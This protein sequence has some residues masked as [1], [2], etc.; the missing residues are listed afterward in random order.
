M[1]QRNVQQLKILTLLLLAGFVL[2]SVA[3][4][5][6]VAGVLSPL[7]ALSA[8]LLIILSRKTQG[9]YRRISLCYA[10]GIGIWFVA[11]LLRLV[12]QVHLS[13]SDVILLL[14][15]NLFLLPDCFFALGLVFFS[16]SEYNL[17]H[18]QRLILNT[19]IIAFSVFL[20]AQRMILKDASSMEAGVQGMVPYSFV[21]VFTIVLVLSIF[22]QTRFTG[23][24]LG[25]NCSAVC[26]IVYNLFEIRMIYLKINGQEVW[27]H[28]I[29]IFYVIS[30]VI[31]AMAQSDPSLIHRKPE[32]SREADER[33]MKTRTLLL[34]ALPVAGFEVG[35]YGV[36]F[37]D[38]RDVY[39]GFIALL[40]YVAVYMIMQAGELNTILLHQ[41]TEENQRLEQLVEEKTRE[42]LAMNEHLTHLSTTDPLTGLY[43][44]RYGMEKIRT[45]SE[46]SPPVPFAIYQMDLNYFKSINDTYGHDAGDLVLKEV[47]KRLRFMMP[48]NV[49]AVRVGGDE[50]FLIL[51]EA[52]SREKILEVA[53]RLCKW[54]D[55]SV[56]TPCAVYTFSASIG[57]ACWPEDSR[58]PD[59]LLRYAD[60]AMY[61]C[62]HRS[63]KSRY[64]R[65]EVE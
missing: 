46:A 54:M 40:A 5:D 10:V 36:H 4:A 3:R 58:A 15:D 9:H 52:D 11:D 1:A 34:I 31:Y 23:H 13:A 24:T 2:A 49:T 17:Q 26:L 33:V 48:E 50:F 37:L 56:V 61:Q 39:F 14:S 8:C 42:L 30:I 35:L 51:E 57:I 22:F 45:L 53:N 29:F 64:L 28:Y 47:G 41:R 19:F 55:E 6:R 20:L 18:F 43:N 44:R 12:Y 16:L 32:Q 65:W 7:V 21:V 62:K 27:N 60:Q 63:E 38:P 59:T 25:T